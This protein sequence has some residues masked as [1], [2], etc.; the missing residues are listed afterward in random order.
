MSTALATPLEA[1]GI[2]R[3]LAALLKGSPVPIA[4]FM[5]VAQRLWSEKFKDCD[6]ETFLECVRSVAGLG[7]NPDPMTK[8]VWLIPRK[9]KEKTKKDVTL[10]VGYQG[11]LTLMYRAGCSGVTAGVI[12]EKDKFNQ[13]TFEYEMHLSRDRGPVVATY[14]VCKF[15]GE[16]IGTIVT[17]DEMDRIM[18]CSQDVKFNGF[19]GS[20][21][22]LWGEEQRKKSALRRLAKLIPWSEDGDALARASGVEDETLPEK[23]L[24]RPPVQGE[25]RSEQMRGLM[26]PEPASLQ[27][28]LTMIDAAT[29]KAQLDTVRPLVLTLGPEEKK[30]AAA[31]F[32]AK[33]K[34]LKNGK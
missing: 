8:Q 31:V 26:E 13:K 2:E 22:D 18:A 24:N 11:F 15:A 25:T 5:A 9:N 1:P 3:N 7:L 30:E 29:T 20:I 27:H 14:A 23:E 4:K 19:K 10:L 16:T 12:H 34:D 32:N 6:P 33:N 17:E 21:W 28:V